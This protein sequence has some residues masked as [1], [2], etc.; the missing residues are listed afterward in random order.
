M[1]SEPLNQSHAVIIAACPAG[2]RVRGK[3]TMVGKKVACPKCQAQFVFAPT[4]RHAGRIAAT[5]RSVTDTA[6]MRILG[7]MPQRPQPPEPTPA[8]QP[9]ITDSGVMRILGDPPESLRH[10]DSPEKR[11]RPCPK[12][13]VPISDALAVCNH[14][15]SY[16]G[17]LPSFLRGLLGGDA[18][19]HN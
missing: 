2:H 4:T 1:T 12:C 6:V 10:D 16:V 3:A 13:S 5:E 18:P 19:Q 14:C 8:E 17:A 9:S 7:D 15:N 11:L